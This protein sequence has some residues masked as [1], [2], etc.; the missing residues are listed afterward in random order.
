VKPVGR[1]SIV[2]TTP[3]C[4]SSTSGVGT[5]KTAGAAKFDYKIWIVAGMG[6]IRF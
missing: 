1:L 2:A 3:H 4:V 5:S 6:G